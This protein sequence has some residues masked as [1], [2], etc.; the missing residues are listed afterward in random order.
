MTL[1]RDGT[2]PNPKDWNLVGTDHE[3]NHELPDVSPT[4]LVVTT[5]ETFVCLE[6]TNSALFSKGSSADRF[7]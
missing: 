2:K 1:L 6:S 3:G 7:L 4:N 5:G